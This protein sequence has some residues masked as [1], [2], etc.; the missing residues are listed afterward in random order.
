LKYSW[1]NKVISDKIF[2]YS[3]GSKFLPG[4][5]PPP[6]TT[7]NWYQADILLPFQLCSHPLL[8]IP[9]GVHHIPSYRSW[10]RRTCSLAIAFSYL[11]PDLRVYQVFRLWIWAYQV[12]PWS[13]RSTQP[14]AAKFV[15]RV[16][17][18]PQSVLATASSV[19]SG[20][21]WCGVR[22]RWLYSIDGIP[23]EHRLGGVGLVRSPTLRP[24]LI[25]KLT[26]CIHA[27]HI[28]VARLPPTLPRGEKVVQSDDHSRYAASTKPP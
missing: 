7:V 2:A 12:S 24:G 25:V 6:V 10:T 17:W 13:T 16:N 14:H 27:A 9:L 11:L 15:P 21:L 8:Y 5:P 3:R 28:Y 23:S 4:I 20:R 1:N 18:R 19:I 26:F 22:C